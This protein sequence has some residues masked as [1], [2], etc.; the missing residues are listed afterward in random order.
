MKG[1]Y[2][3]IW[4]YLKNPSNYSLYYLIFL[5]C[6]AGYY[7]FTYSIQ[8]GDTDLWYHLN[9]GRYSA[10]RHSL[11][12]TSFFSFLDP[13]RERPDYY[14][15]FRICVYKIYDMAGYQGLII[16]RGL[17]YLAIISTILLYL[18]KGFKERRGDWACL[19]LFLFY[20][21]LMVPRYQAVRPHILS[22]SLIPAFIYFFENRSIKILILPVLAV[23]WSNVHGITYPIIVLLCLAYLSEFIWELL[24]SKEVHHPNH[25]GYI[26]IT[27]IVLSLL[28]ILATPYGVKLLAVPFISTFY[29]SQYIIELSTLSWRDLF[30]LNFWPVSYQTLVNITVF[31]TFFTVLASAAYKK[32]RISHLILL[33]GGTY[34][35]AKSSRFTYEFVLLAL[36]ILKNSLLTCWNNS[37]TAMDKA[38]HRVLVAIFVLLLTTLPC[39][40]FYTLA[41][42]LRYPLSYE[43]LPAGVVTFLKHIDVGGTILNHPNNGGYLEWELY[44]RYKIAMDMQVPHLFTDADMFFVSGAFSNMEIARKFIALYKPDFICVPME[45]GNR[46]AFFR[47]KPDYTLVFFDDSD[48]LYV[49]NKN[50]PD[51]A[52]Q[53]ILEEINPHQIEELDVDLLSAEK[54]EK[55]CKELLKIS[56]MYSDGYQINQLLAMI[57]GKQGNYSKAIEYAEKVIHL[58]PESA[59]GYR[60]KGNFLAIQKLY[61]AAILSYDKAWNL[62]DKKEKKEIYKRLGGCYLELRQYGDAYNAFSH[63]F[64]IYDGKI[65]YREIYLMALSA[66][67]L[68]KHVEALELFKFAY[69]KTPDNDIEWLQKIANNMKKLGAVKAKK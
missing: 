49:N 8:A 14:W 52:R 61:P 57:Y 25:E 59:K 11:P 42:P 46:T 40:F 48:I 41:K 54:M 20:L 65:T 50:H 5:Y 39:S 16:F 32:P 31:V 34:L 69:L 19:L 67:Y 10:E 17:A 30:C 47:Q 9:G 4:N 53:Y 21:V 33:G 6:I 38:T 2:S 27:A 7:F 55:L 60:L 36:P 24:N 64:N 3:K 12:E 26:F 51:I 15:L 44:P 45:E 66:Q 62:A 35:L 23:L 63:A 28:A 18:R 1:L 37:I 22:Y 29:A 68:G 13:P 56:R 58:R 43:N